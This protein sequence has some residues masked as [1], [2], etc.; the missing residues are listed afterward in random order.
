MDVSAPTQLHC[1]GCPSL[2]PPGEVV[3]YAKRGKEAVS[4][5]AR[6]GGAK[7]SHWH[8]PARCSVCGRLVVRDT[9]LSTPHVFCC[10]LHGE[11]A[12]TRRK[13]KKRRPESSTRICVAEGC[14]NPCYGRGD[15]KTCGD[16]CRKRMERARKDG[17]E[18]QA[19][20]RRGSW[21]GAQ[22]DRGS[23][24][25]DPGPFLAWFRGWRA[26]N[27]DV[28]LTALC[29]WAD[30]PAGRI[31]TLQRRLRH[32]KEAHISLRDVAAFLDAAHADPHE[33]HALYPVEDGA[34]VEPTDFSVA[35]H[36]E[37]GAHFCKSWGC[38]RDNGHGD[39][40]NFCEEHGALLER[41][42]VECENEEKAQR[43]RIGGPAAPV[44][45]DEFDSEPR[46]RLRRGGE[47]RG[48]LA[49]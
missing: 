18:Q 2:I 22:I 3:F 6:C 36:R 38:G 31:A 44:D 47:V 10:K 23:V 32:R 49:A 24:R 42:R 9:R 11:R 40:G 15:R 39:R 46:W 16:A 35:Q 17:T 4:L 37:H 48:L 12:R 34:Q 8:A 30:V 45:D 33:L 14:E 13:R 5:C 29:E 19:Q 20:R 43:H 41:I 25:L 28:P 21:A 26:L 1:Q 27:P 7:S